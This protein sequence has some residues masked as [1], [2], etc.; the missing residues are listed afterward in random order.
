M[1]TKD[2]E[3]LKLDLIKYCNQMGIS[4]P[5][6]RLI[7]DRS[8]YHALKIANGQE[9]HSGG[10]GECN[11]ELRTIFVDAG[12][13][14]YHTRKYGKI[15]KNTEIEKLYNQSIERYGKGRVLYYVRNN[16][17]DTIRFHHDGRHYRYKERK[18]STYKH[19]LKLLIHELVHY[20]FKSLPHGR[21]FEER[22]REVLLQGKTFPP[23]T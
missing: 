5:Y 8:E 17:N 23:T 16:G 22:I 21:K 1:K 19:K 3:R 15:R 12:A 11:L 20:R 2:K 13:R 6:P 14:F 7:L 18:K 10:Y 4:Q 9:K